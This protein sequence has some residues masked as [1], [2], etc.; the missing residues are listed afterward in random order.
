MTPSHSSQNPS[1]SDSLYNRKL[2]RGRGVVENAFGIL[3][4]SWY[5]L[6]NKTELEVTYLPDVF[7]CCSILHNLLLGQSSGDVERLLGV[8][9]AEG[10]EE[11]CSTDK[12]HGI[13]HGLGDFELRERPQGQEL[14]RSLGIFLGA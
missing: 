2:R 1:I 5:E 11:D 8:L 14:Q 9:A 7:L 4:Q 12:A 3:K 6:L 13:D 10:W